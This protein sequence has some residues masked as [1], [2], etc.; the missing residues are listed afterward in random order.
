MWIR[1][2][3][4]MMALAAPAVAAPADEQT[5]SSPPPLQR[6]TPDF[7]FGK[8]RGSVG[9]RGSWFFARAASDWYAFVTDH[10]TLKRNDFNAP[11]F[12]VDA[13][14]A[15]TSRLD[16]V[17]ALEYSRTTTVSEYRRFVDNNRL[18]INQ[19][20]GLRELNLSGGVK[21]ALTERGREVSRLAWVPRTVVPYVGAGGGMLWF[22][23]FQAGDFVDFVDL[24]VFTDRFATEGWAPSAHVFGG[25]DVRVLRRLFVTFDG[26][27]LWAAG[28]L[29]ADWVDFDPIDLGGVRL[30][31]GFNVVF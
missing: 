11:A 30:S 24:R 12:G 22:N 14:V 19:E 17:F 18:P 4:G 31:A 5:P 13:G 8:P 21:F 6:P 2:I 28:Q 29:G 25:V 15:V 3:V 7:L 26:R 27:Y 16:A 20:T 23:V 10:L 1:L 9:F